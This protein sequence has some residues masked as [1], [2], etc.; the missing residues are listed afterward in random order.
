MEAQQRIGT[1]IGQ[2]RVE[3]ARKRAAE[4]AR[5]VSDDRAVEKRRRKATTTAE[6]TGPTFATA[7]TLD[8]LT[9][10]AVAD[11]ARSAPSWRELIRWWRHQDALKPLSTAMGDALCEVLGEYALLLPWTDAAG[12]VVE[13]LRAVVPGAGGPADM[14][15]YNRRW[16]DLPEPRPSHVVGILVDAWLSNQPVDRDRRRPG[17]L[18]ESWRDSRHYDYLPLQNHPYPDPPGLM[19]GEQ[20]LL[21]LAELQPSVIVPVLPLALYDSGTGPMATRGRGAPYAQRLF[22]EILLDVGRLDRVPGQT[23]RV[24][25]TLRELVAWLWPNGWKRTRRGDRLGDLQ[26]LQ[27]ELLILDSIRVLWERMLWRLVAVQALPTE[28]SHMEDRIVFRVEHLPGS[29][30]GPMIDR[31][32]LRR[33]GTVSAPAWRA[34]LRLAYLW[35]SA[36]RKNNGARIYPTRLVVARGP[37]GVILGANGKPLRDHRGAVVTDW[38]DRR[39][40][41]LGANGKPA[42]ADNPPAYERNPAADRVPVLGPDDLIRLAFDDNLNLPASTRRWRLHEARKVARVFAEAGDVVVEQ[43]GEG[44]RLIEQRGGHAQTLSAVSPA[45]IEQVPPLPVLP[46]YTVG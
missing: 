28:T 11:G 40:V 32:R 25:I 5:G 6:R 42:G 22:V 7:T 26:I 31:D 8:E 45:I 41:I 46:A 37:G 23:A 3:E 44:W 14:M 35:D 16:L 1:T 17:I 43:V 19:A 33:F 18:P 2:Q 13:D 12:V 21:P 34:Y 4:K 15:E 27:R 36:K 38:S 20:H 9:Q 39:A 10:A 24:E 29:E 30:H